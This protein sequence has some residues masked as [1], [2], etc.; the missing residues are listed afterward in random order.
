MYKLSVLAMFKNEGMIIEEWLQHYIDEGVEHFFLIDNGSTD[1]YE[2]KIAKFKSFYTLVKDG[3]RLPKNT[4][5]FLYTKY[6]LDIIKKT[7]EWLIICDIDEYIYARNGYS[8]IPDILNKLPKEIEQIWI[9]WKIFNSNGH[10]KQPKSIV[11]SFIKYYKPIEKNR[12]LGKSVVRTTNLI[13][14]DAH[15]QIFKNKTPFYTSNGDSYD[16]YIFSHENVLRLNLHLNHY[17]LMSEEYYKNIKCTRGGGQSG[18]SSK[19]TMAA[20]YAFDNHY[21]RDSIIDDELKMK[22]ACA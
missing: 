6:Y 12:G 20:F 16:T 13:S 17:M 19:Y 21:D 4:Q 7:T 8:K 3:T 5:S 14:L 22:K 18:T 15:I 2:E 9:P 11:Q 10:K 1:D